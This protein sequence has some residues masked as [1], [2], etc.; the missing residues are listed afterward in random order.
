MYTYFL[1][2]LKMQFTKYQ[3]CS[4]ILYTIV[5]LTEATPSSGQTP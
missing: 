2:A 3:N 5:V 1:H 4:Q